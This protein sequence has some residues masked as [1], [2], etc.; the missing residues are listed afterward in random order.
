ST[1]PALFF[2]FRINP[3]GNPDIGS[4]KLDGDGIPPDFFSDPDVRKGFACAMDYQALIRDTFMGA[5][6]RA[7][8]PVPPGVPGYDPRQPYYRFDLKKAAEHLRKAWGGRVWREG[9][10]FTLTYNVG[11]ENRQA[12]CEI[13]KKNVESLNPKFKI[14]LRGVEWA[15]FL[16][17]AQRRLMPIFARGWYADY[18]DAHNFVY[19]FYDS[20]GRYPSAQGFRDP[21]LDRLIEEAAGQ[22]N[23]RRRAALYRRILALGY[24]DVPSIVTVHTSE[25]VALRSWVRGFYRNPVF[26][27]NYYYPLGKD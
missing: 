13:L 22:L 11:S 20:D 9:F 14:D 12:A 26:L 16:D 3:L 6:V 5:A 4:G 23:G 10:R 17:K 27:G 1:D 25:V 18:P 21:E 15:S 8:G 24:K 7:K 19:A 2:T